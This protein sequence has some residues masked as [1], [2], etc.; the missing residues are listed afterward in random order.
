[1]PF[2]VRPNGPGFTLVGYTY[3]DGPMDGELWLD[4]EDDL[5]DWEIT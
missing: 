2:I 4:N 1:M 5:T 3:I